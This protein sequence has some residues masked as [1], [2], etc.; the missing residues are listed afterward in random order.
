MR[1]EH[2]T[3]TWLFEVMMVR[4]GFEIVDATYSEDRIDAQ[5]V[6]RAI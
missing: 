2:S 5:Y 1:D 3:F 6:L 4:S